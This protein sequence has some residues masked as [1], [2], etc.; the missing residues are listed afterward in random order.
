MIMI[1]SLLVPARA[2]FEPGGLLLVLVRVSL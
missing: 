1:S 2:G